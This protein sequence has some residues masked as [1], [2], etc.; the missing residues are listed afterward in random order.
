MAERPQRPVAAPGSRSHAPSRKPRP[1]G[2]EDTL[3]ETPYV[4]RRSVLWGDCDPAEM[5]YTPRFL[6]YVAEAVDGWFRDVLEEDWY[7]IKA[8]RGMVTPIMHATLDF[9]ERL[10]PGDD[11]ELTVLVEE[12]HRS[13]MSF[14]VK[15]RNGEGKDA[16]SARLVHSIVEYTSFRSVAWPDEIRERATAYRAACGAVKAVA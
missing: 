16:F 8:R 10:Q 9:F 14:R 6:D 1:A 7:Q 5:V 2:P 13:T 4:M 12:V 11:I 3:I 15:A